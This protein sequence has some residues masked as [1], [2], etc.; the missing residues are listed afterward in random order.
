MQYVIDTHLHIYPFYSLSNALKT[1]THNLYRYNKEAIKVGCLTERFDCNIYQQLQQSKHSEATLD[2]LGEFQIIASPSGN[3][4]EIKT[5]ESGQTIHLLPGQQIITAENLE[6]L[7]LNCS[8]RV[9]E[10][11]PA[12]QTIDKVLSAGGIPVIAFGFGKWL[13]KRGE[14]VHQLIER[15]SA[16]EICMG[17]TTMRPYGWT[18]PSAFRHAQKKG[19]KVLHGS[20]PL[21][22]PGEESRP[23][24]YATSASLGEADPD[25]AVKQL[26]NP[27][28]HPQSV[29]RRNS[30][31][32][33]ARRMHN[34]RQH[35]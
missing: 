6:I 30:V 3:S 31:I 21:P 23:G 11:L 4:L 26:L 33:V 34:H 32:E 27:E 2:S 35:G 8:T 13:G 25:M 19:I 20:D 17:D 24:S 5:T 12:E 1:L 14:I 29:G 22:F 16:E 28:T 9:T 15:Y 18:T 10:G 7:S